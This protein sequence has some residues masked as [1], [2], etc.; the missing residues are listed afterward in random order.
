MHVPLTPI[1][2]L[3]RALDLYPNKTAVVAGDARYTYA[4]FADR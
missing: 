2:C 1:R 4:E 3:L